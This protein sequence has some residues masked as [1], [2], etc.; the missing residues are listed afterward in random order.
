MAFFPQIIGG[1][2]LVDDAPRNRICLRIDKTTFGIH[3]LHRLVPALHRLVGYAVL[4]LVLRLLQIR[5]RP[6]WL[7]GITPVLILIRIY[8]TIPEKEKP[9]W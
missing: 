4:C 5:L 2:R 8:Y 6:F 3:V 9:A 7:H 1:I